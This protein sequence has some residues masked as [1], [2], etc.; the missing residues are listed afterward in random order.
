MQPA[1]DWSAYINRGWEPGK[2]ARLHENAPGLSPLE[3]EKQG[4]FKVS[5][6]IDPEVYPEELVSAALRRMNVC[7]NIVQSHGRFLDLLPARASKGAAV[8]F[9]CEKFAAPLDRAIVCGDSGND[10]DMLFCGVRRRNERPPFGVQ[11][12]IVDIPTSE[13]LARSSTDLLNLAWDIGLEI[14]STLKNSDVEDWDDDGTARQDY[15]SASQ[16]SLG[17]A[18]AI[19]QQ[20]Q[21]L[22]LKARIAKVSPYLLIAGDPRGWPKGCQKNDIGFGDFRTIDAS[23]LLRVHDTVCTERA[24]DDFVK[25]FEETRRRRNLFVHLGRQRQHDDAV[26][27]LR[28]V[29]QT[30]RALFPDRRWA[31]YRYDFSQRTGVVAV[32]GSDYVEANL[33]GEFKTIV[34][35]LSADELREHF[36]FDAQA[37]RYI[38]VNCTAE[39]RSMSGEAPPFAQLRPN[40]PEASVLYCCVCDREYPIVRKRCTLSG[41]TSDVFADDGTCLICLGYGHE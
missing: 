1:A 8:R 6:Y 38:C 23:D 13:E 33:V 14:V 39:E 25:L 28:L 29:L 27:I 41:C 22:G 40:T 35:L 12:M 37:Q 21:E 34:D 2:L 32:Y 7:A 20:A 30:V 19:I 16:A 11:G 10:R 17:N 5:F 18:L 24:G 9:L 4:P 3:P 15:H 26:N 36:S 31:H